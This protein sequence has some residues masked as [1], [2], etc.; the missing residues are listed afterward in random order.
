[1][2]EWI[3]LGRLYNLV[4]EEGERS[5]LVVLSN[6]QEQFVLLQKGREPARQYCV[7]IFRV[8]KRD[9]WV[10]ATSIMK[11]LWSCREGIGLNSNNFQVSICRYL[12]KKRTSCSWW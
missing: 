2:H 7:G 1:M 10:S 11:R 5:K 8:P 12:E 9:A 4:M 3:G 6:C